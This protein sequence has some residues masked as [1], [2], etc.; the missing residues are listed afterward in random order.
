M[1]GCLEQPAVFLGTL[2]HEEYLKEITSVS[3]VP[4][5]LARCVI[6]TGSGIQS[7]K[8]NA[9]HAA[10]G[11]PVTDKRL[12]SDIIKHSSPEEPGW[13]H[14]QRTSFRSPMTWSPSSLLSIIEDRRENFSPPRQEL[15]VFRA[16][17]LGTIEHKTTPA[18]WAGTNDQQSCAHLIHR[19]STGSST[20]IG[21]SGKR[22]GIN[23]G[24]KGC[25]GSVR[26]QL[27]HLE[28]G[29]PLTR[30]HT[31][32]GLTPIVLTESRPSLG[33]NNVGG[34][35]PPKINGHFS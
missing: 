15:A 28:P 16:S 22:L 12:H 6:V 17:S 5:P 26:R 34:A 18:G 10:K 1:A 33:R 7:R 23:F 35:F 11:P 24:L 9:S 14:T 20:A 25:T 3:Q 30:E 21:A 8:G 4:T 13:L 27:P 2:P 29:F 32:V 31:H 19:L